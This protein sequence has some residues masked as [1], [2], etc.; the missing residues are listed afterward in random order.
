MLTLLYLLQ[1][2]EQVSAGG[3]STTI[4]STRKKS[5]NND[6]NSKRETSLKLTCSASTVLDIRSFSNLTNPEDKCLF[7]DQTVN[8]ASL[9]DCPTIPTPQTSWVI[10][11]METV[12]GF[13]IQSQF[14][15]LCIYTSLPILK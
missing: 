2:A 3:S 7:N 9:I 4:L 11:K 8:V 13:T 5:N 1:L 12:A 15:S 6:K 14:D 10:K